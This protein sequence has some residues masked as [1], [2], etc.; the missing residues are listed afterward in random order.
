[1]RNFAGM[2]F[3]LL[4]L[5]ALLGACVS[6]EIET[7]TAVSETVT[8]A[9]ERD[10]V[11]LDVGELSEE[12]SY[13]FPES[14]LER[15]LVALTS[16]RLSDIV[17]VYETDGNSVN[18][19]LLPANSQLGETINGEDVIANI[20]LAYAENIENFN[21]NII[22]ASYDALSVSIEFDRE[23]DFE[24]DYLGLPIYPISD[25]ALNKDDS[26]GR[27]YVEGEGEL[28]QHIELV[29]STAQDNKKLRFVHY[30]FDTARQM[31]EAGELDV[32]QLPR[33]N[34][35]QLWADT[36]GGVRVVKQP[37]RYVYMIGFGPMVDYDTRRFL[38]DTLKRSEFIDGYLDGFADVSRY[39][40]GSASKAELPPI[41]YESGE[42]EAK[43]LKYICFVDSEWSYSLCEYLSKTLAAKNIALDVLYTDFQSMLSIAGAEDSE[44]VFAFAWD[45]GA[46]TDP[47]V[48][49]GEV[50]EG[51]VTDG[52][53][54]EEFEELYLS[55][56]PV[57][58]V[59]R[60]FDNIVVR[61]SE[62]L[63]LI[64]SEQ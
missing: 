22:N 12:R 58:A 28:A 5:S 38:A 8:E 50:F 4:C 10:Y 17:S 16:V 18:F 9:A 44:Y 53:L 6:Q 46:G 64:D 61:S 52:A 27:Y 55:A 7:T 48:L 62:F 41:S 37:S 57:I 21:A 47:R 33:T 59:A 56:L 63:G 26:F 14:A 20:R 35:A 51:A 45:L 23:V 19:A 1:M 60:P 32:L 31:F 34:S 43:T 3:V 39:P 54:S 24:R 30:G 36:L 15:R 25:G 42:L 40:L 49:L 13:Y 2:I 29:S 11:L